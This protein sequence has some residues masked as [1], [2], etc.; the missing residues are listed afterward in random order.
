MKTLRV[1]SWNIHANCGIRVERLNRVIAAIKKFSADIILLQE[2]TGRGGV[3]ETIRGQLALPGW[4]FS[5]I[6]TSDKKYGNVIASRYPVRARHYETCPVPPWPQLLAYATVDTPAG[7]LEVVSAHMPNGSEHGW[8]KIETFEA[9]ASMLTQVAGRP[10]IVGGD[11]N[12]PQAILPGNRVISFA[13]NED[14]DVVG[15]WRGRPN[16]RWQAAVAKILGPTSTNVHAWLSRNEGLVATTHVV[17]G[18]PRFFDH[19]LASE[20]FEILDAGFEHA[21]RE[22][23]EPLSDHSGAWMAA[24]LKS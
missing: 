2:V 9:L 16:A 14:G 5:G 22:A 6:N 24:S 17:R 4:H 1:L 19:L 10:W 23:T 18:E 13:A 8:K 7:A 15:Q 11:F 21:W 3:P 20:H 12:E